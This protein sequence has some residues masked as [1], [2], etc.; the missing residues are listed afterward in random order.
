[1]TLSYIINFLSREKP[2]ERLQLKIKMQPEL[3]QIANYNIYPAPEISFEEELPH[4]V[5]VHADLIETESYSVIPQG[6]QTETSRQM[7]TGAQLKTFSGLKLSKKRVIKKFLKEKG[8]LP[9]NMPFCIRFS[10]DNQ[11]WHTRAFKILSSCS[12]LPP[13]L[14]D[15]IRPFAA[16]TPPIPPIPPIPTP[17][18]HRHPQ[19]ASLETESPNMALMTPTTMLPNSMSINF[20]VANEKPPSDITVQQGK[21][22]KKPTGKRK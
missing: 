22:K 17:Y 19:L 11:Y 3:Y 6:F 4:E 2:V 16:P 12:Q 9:K 20:I 21:S 18:Q 5:T 7:R 15:S 13:D 10:V 8:L 14:R 1:M